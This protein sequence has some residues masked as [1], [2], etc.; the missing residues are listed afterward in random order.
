MGNRKKIMQNMYV[1]QK[2]YKKGYLSL[3]GWESVRCYMRGDYLGVSL[4]SPRR[5]SFRYSSRAQDK[6]IRKFENLL[7]SHPCKTPKIDTNIFGIMMLWHA[8]IITQKNITELSLKEEKGCLIISD[9]RYVMSDWTGIDPLPGAQPHRVNYAFTI[10]TKK[11]QRNTQKNP[12]RA[13]KGSQDQYVNEDV[14][15]TIPLSVND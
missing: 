7:Q 5:E 10:S 1:M 9:I 14:I 15:D 3:F 8:G 13:P 11:P 2:G 6:F 12:W 4:T